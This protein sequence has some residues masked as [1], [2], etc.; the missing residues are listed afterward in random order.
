METS[1]Q[2][3]AARLGEVCRAPVAAIMAQGQVRRPSV[4]LSAAPAGGPRRR[5]TR[6]LL[7]L[8]SCVG[9]AAA[10]TTPPPPPPPEPNKTG[11]RSG[12]VE[13]GGQP[14]RRASA[15]V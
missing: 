4:R 14:Q 3:E 2:G 8:S 15:A 1:G 12:H 6:L 7:L 13:G 5:T 10:L 9:S 11:E